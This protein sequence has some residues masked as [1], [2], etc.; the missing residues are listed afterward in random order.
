MPTVHSHSKRSL[1]KGFFAVILAFAAVNLASAGELH[2]II[3]SLHN[4]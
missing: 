1:L 2:F 4:H 3:F